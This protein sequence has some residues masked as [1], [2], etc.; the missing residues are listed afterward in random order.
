MATRRTGHDIRSACHWTHAGL[1]RTDRPRLSPASAPPPHPDRR[2]GQR[3]LP[4]KTRPARHR[5]SV[6]DRPGPALWLST[7]PRLQVPGRA[8]ARPRDPRV[9]ARSCL[10]FVAILPGLETTPRIQPR[11]PPYATPRT[12]SPTPSLFEHLNNVPAKTRSITRDLKQGVVSFI[13]DRRTELAPGHPLRRPGPFRESSR[14]TR[15]VLS[16]P[17]RF[18]A[19]GACSRLRATRAQASRPATRPRARALARRVERREQLLRAVIVRHV[20]R[21]PRW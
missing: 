3:D 6:Q 10:D 9:V 21:T 17:P 13:S 15:L 12:L 5:D 20:A 7:M 14:S 1:G 19:A 8:Y 16:P 2:G 18:G 4:P 11:T